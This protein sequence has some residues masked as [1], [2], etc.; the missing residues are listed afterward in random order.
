MGRGLVGCLL[1][2]KASAL[3]HSER[4]PVRLV[5]VQ[6]RLVGPY[7]GSVLLPGFASHGRSTIR[8]VSTGQHV[9][10]QHPGAPYHTPVLRIAYR[11]R[12]QIALWLPTHSESA[13]MQA[14]PLTSFAPASFPMASAFA[15]S[16]APN[17]APTLSQCRTPSVCRTLSQCRPSR[18]T[19]R[20]C[21]TWRA[22]M[23]QYDS[24]AHLCILCGR[25]CWRHRL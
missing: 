18:S 2:H 25:P 3:V 7:A 16:A 11:R 9:D 6:R 13:R 19:L 17:P 5:H 21:P 4:D 15:S 20:Q 12:G 22:D 24:G 14:G 10:R 8:R 23:A 1:A